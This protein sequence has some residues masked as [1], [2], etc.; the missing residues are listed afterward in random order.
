MTIRDVHTNPTIYPEPAT[1]NP[2]RWMNVNDRKR[3]DAYRVPFSKGSHSCIGK[4]LAIV[5]LYLTLANMFS[6]FDMKLFETSE[7]DISMEHDFF[8]P[9]GPSDSKGVRVTIA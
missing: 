9:F 4:D 3:Q 8:A 7:R 2:E 6:R 5:E 1:F